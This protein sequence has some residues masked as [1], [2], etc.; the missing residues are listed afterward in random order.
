[1]ARH[2]NADWDLSDSA[3]WDVVHAALAM[4]LR[5][6]LQDLNATL[7]SINNNILQLGTDGLHE[8]LQDERAKRRKA[9]RLKLEKQRAARRARK[10]TRA[11]GGQ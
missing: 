3:S 6:Q 10:A 1:M 11:H 4:D 9:R 7:R 8:I 2:K 5:D